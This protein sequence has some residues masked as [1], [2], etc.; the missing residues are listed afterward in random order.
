MKNIFFW[1]HFRVWMFAFF[2]EK[3]SE[4]LL[5]IKTIKPNLSKWIL[6]KCPSKIIFLLVY[7]LHSYVISNVP[8]I[9][10]C[11]SNKYFVISMLQPVTYRYILYIIRYI[12]YIDV[13][14]AILINCKINYGRSDVGDIYRRKVK[15]YVGE[16]F[17]SINL[18][19]KP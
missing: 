8:R 11:S 4:G 13:F 15:V 7:E 19:F 18:C 1:N 16:E 17:P 9:W 3:N 2:S 5:F 10:H 6:H 12:M 14:T